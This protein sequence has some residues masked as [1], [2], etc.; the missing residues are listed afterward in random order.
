MRR[1]P[2]EPEGELAA[3]VDE[4]LG[5]LEGEAEMNTPSMIRAGRAR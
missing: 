2:F 5:D 4:G 1:Q 3:K